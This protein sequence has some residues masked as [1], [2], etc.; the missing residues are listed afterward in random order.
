P[1]ELRHGQAARAGGVGAQARSRERRAA[2]EGRP[3]ARRRVASTSSSTSASAV[4]RAPAPGLPD[5]DFDREVGPRASQPGT[6]KTDTRARSRADAALPYRVCTQTEPDEPLGGKDPRVREEEPP[7]R[8]RSRLG[9]CAASLRLEA[10]RR[11]ERA[12]P[13]LPAP[14]AHAVVPRV[15]EPA[16]PHDG[17]ADVRAGDAL[18][19]ALDEVAVEL[20]AC[21]ART[22]EPT[23]SRCAH[24]ERDDHERTTPTHLHPLGFTRRARSRAT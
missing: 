20:L 5:T 14:L 21:R 15:V 18:L 16:P 12:V 10:R 7:T 4:A 8:T 1:H 9:G 17:L 23:A 3:A 2:G 19:P 13:Q 22:D 24:D 6:E 11:R